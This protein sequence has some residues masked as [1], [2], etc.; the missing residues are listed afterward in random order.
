MDG[1]VE[2]VG[3]NEG[4]IELVGEK[5][6]DGDVELVGLNE[7]FVKLVGEKV[8]DG[9]VEVEGEN[10]NGVPL[11]STSLLSP[12]PRAASAIPKTVAK[13]MMLSTSNFFWCLFHQGRDSSSTSTAS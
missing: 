4:F 6:V 8:V 9:D 1:D 3:L 13:R 11:P 5:V 12:D 10:D 2:L 7:G